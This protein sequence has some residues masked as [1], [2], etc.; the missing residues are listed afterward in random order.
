ML[1]QHLKK[2][3]SEGKKLFALLI[4]PDKHTPE[5]IEKLLVNL[6][7]KP[8]PDLILVGGS[9]LFNGVSQIIAAIKRNSQTPVFLFPGNVQHVSENADG[10]LLL[11][12]ISGRNPEFLIGNHVQAAPMIR[13]AGL[14]VIPTGYLLI[15]SG[16]STSVSYMSNTA[17]IP[18]DKTDIAVATAMA[19][20]MLG[21]QLIY[22]EAGS[23]AQIPVSER[24][25]TAVKTNIRIPLVVGGGIK[26]AEQLS[27]VLDAGADM[28]VVGTA[29]ETNS[30]VVSEF[31]AYFTQRNRN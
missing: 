23:G 18:Y 5:S 8:G 7:N 17:P 14:E 4:D 25:I 15:N 10:I 9:L 11:S 29:A 26:T 12:L 21:M 27:K 1:I 13:K 31:A 19:G 2:Q 6:I 30:A 24:M 22:L 28:V 3:F 20:E 16:V